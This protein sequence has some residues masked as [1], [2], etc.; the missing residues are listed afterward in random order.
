MYLNHYWKTGRYRVS[1]RWGIEQQAI[2]C[3]NWPKRCHGI[4]R[5]SP[6]RRTLNA[7]GVFNTRINDS[8]SRIVVIEL[9]IS[10]SSSAKFPRWRLSI[11]YTEPGINTCS[12]LEI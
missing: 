1:E 6:L 4:M 11:A 8:G 7:Y 5:N 12:I 2:L 10:V 3:A 9:D